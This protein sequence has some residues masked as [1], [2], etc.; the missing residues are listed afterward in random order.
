MAKKFLT[1]M[2][3]LLSASLF[4]IGCPTEPEDGKPGEAGGQGSDAGFTIE[5]NKSVEYVQD[6]IDFYQGK[7]AM[8]DFYN[9]TITGG[10]VVDFG[11]VKAHIYGTLA[12]DS[13]TTEG[14]AILNL[15]AADVTFGTGAEIAL[16]DA[17]DVAL[18]KAEYLDYAGSTG[19]YAQG[20]GG[21]ADFADVAGSVTAV[22]NLLL[23]STAAA[24]PATLTIYVY[25]TLTLNDAVV[26]ASGK[27][28]AIRNVAVSGT[29]GDVSD[30]T[31]V[32]VS[33]AQI[34]VV[35]NGQAAVKLPASL[36]ASRFYLSGGQEALTVTGTTDIS[37]H[38]VAGNGTLVLG[39]AVTHAAITGY[40][41]IE[42]TNGTTATGFTSAS[43]VA[44][45]SVNFT[46][47]FSTADN[48]LVTLDG[49]VVI[50]AGK[51]ITLGNGSGGVTLAEGLVL[52]VDSAAVLSVDSDIT[53]KATS[54]TGAVLTAAA[55]KLT[56]GTQALTMSGNAGVEAG[57]TLE[58]NDV[59]VTIDTNSYLAL[60]GT[61]TIAIT[62]ATSGTFAGTVQVNTPANLATLV[63]ETFA[64][65]DK[66]TR[67][68]L[69]SD[70][71]LAAA[72]TVPAD[73]TV[74]VD[75]GGTLTTHADG[76]A[77]TAAGIL[78]LVG[79]TGVGGGKVSGK[80]TAGTTTFAGDWQAQA[81]T[82]ETFG[83]ISITSAETG[84][85]IAGVD[86][87]GTAAAVTLKAVSGATNPTITQAA[88]ASNDL[89]IAEDTTIDLGGTVASKL[90]EIVLK[91]SS[92]TSADNNGK[93][94]L[95]GT[96]TTGN[97]AGASQ[98]EGAP[99]SDDSTTVVFDATT[100]TKIGV[101]LLTG[102]GSVA[103][104]VATN[105]PNTNG[106]T[107]AAGNL[108]KLLG[109]G[110]ATVT[111]GDTSSTTTGEADGKISAATATV[112]DATE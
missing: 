43:S 26:P 31:K 16:G 94:S 71:T 53:L 69:T 74:A 5:G 97:T 7:T 62:S 41:N 87:A 1:G 68:V 88:E 20:V 73:V 40:G 105:D 29:V 46:N 75:K 18:L 86:A 91:N 23:G 92:A 54:D 39:G 12:T 24:Y 67:I 38:V 77:I 65:S 60:D 58:A 93:L 63:G 72:L 55:N 30:D 45:T 66:I 37:A 108:A 99:L 3:V 4:F 57:A 103:K 48:Q 96:I 36:A 8:L 21:P 14:A 2:A 17:G 111:G 61:G 10:G 112:A 109:G 25:G 64:G 107:S 89:V 11:A 13:V 104:I 33:M 34:S 95:A 9:V 52:S 27:V 78:A 100:Y 35:N 82:D 59:A 83:A 51:T 44:G 28:V 56:A 101:L 79:D 84:A 15:V 47:G 90:G 6:K 76:I 98:A 22:E 42:F 19:I 70:A 102:D 81:V 110:S 80:I 49:P 50:P 32:D 106:N 85:T